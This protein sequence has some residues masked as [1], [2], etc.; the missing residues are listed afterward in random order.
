MTA[1]PSKK[2]VLILFVA[3]LILTVSQPANATIYQIPK[4]LA[5]ECKVFQKAVV[6]SPNNAAAHFNLAMN[7]AY[8]GR[9]LEGWS[10]LKKV[11]ELDPN[12]AKKVLAEYE[13]KAK[14][15]PE[16]WK[17]PFKLAFGYYFLNRKDDAEAQFK[18]ILKLYPN[19]VWAMGYIALLEG[20]KQHYDVTIDWCHKGLAI[21]PDATALH[22][23]EGEALAKSGHH[24]AAIGKRLIVLKYLAEESSRRKNK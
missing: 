5:D 14:A 23:L 24:I 19:H 9:I 7:Y 10:S 8:T 3:A 17:N 2:W 22:F 6:A 1:L 4:D 11:N 21:E 12:Y 16:D 15:H 13:P 20:E 18:S